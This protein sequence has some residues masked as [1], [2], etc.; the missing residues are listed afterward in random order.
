[1]NCK[2]PIILA[3]FMA[4]Y[5]TASILY[6]L[7]TNCGNVGTPFKDAL[8]KHPELK[9]IKKKS[10]DTRRSI[11][12]SSLTLACLLFAILRPFEECH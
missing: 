8:E 9:E 12:L 1:M 11:Y 6:L 5:Q 2:L 7:I 3:Y 4:I 10:V